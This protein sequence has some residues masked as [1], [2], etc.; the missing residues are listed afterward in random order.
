MAEATVPDPPIQEVE[1]QERLEFPAMHND[2]AVRLGEMGVHVIRETG[3]NLAV[4]VQLRGDVV[5]R[6]KLGT[7][8][9]QN[10]PWLAKKADTA[11]FFG[12]SS[13]LAKLRAKAEG[14]TLA[15]YPGADPEHLT[16]NG[17]AFPI[18]VDGEVVGTITMSGEPDVVDHETAVL[19]V[20]RFLAAG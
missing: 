18:R 19:A 2:D 13:L 10:D 11:R 6:A 12:T 3:R 1:A 17:G 7:T 4:E 5:F 15:D 20:E 14:K 8:G 16:L 9:I